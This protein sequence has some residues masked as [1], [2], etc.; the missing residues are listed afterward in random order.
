MKLFASL[1]GMSMLALAQTQDLSR[2]VSYQS[3]GATVNSIL[4]TLQKETG[5]VLTTTAETGKD[6]VFVDVKDVPLSQFLEQLSLAVG[7]EWSR[8]AGGFRLVRT[9]AL[10]QRQSAEDRAITMTRL[11]AA[12]AKAVTEG[13]INEPFDPAEMTRSAQEMR[14]QLE[15]MRQNGGR[16]EFRMP[17]VIGP[18]GRMLFKLLQLVPADVLAFTRTGERHVFATNPTAMQK[19]LASV[20][21][22]IV[23]QSL[24]EQANFLQSSQRGARNTGRDPRQNQVSPADRLRN[25]QIGKIYVI[26]T[27][28]SRL[29][30]SF[31]ARVTDVN[32]EDLMFG[33]TSLQLDQ[34]V[35]APTLQPW[36]GDGGTIDFSP[37][38]LEFSKF[39]TARR[40]L[41]QVNAGSS[42][43]MT[44]PSQELVEAVLNPLQFEPLA[45]IPGEGLASLQAVKKTNTIIML[46]DE[47]LEVLNRQALAGQVKRDAF[48][49]ALQTDVGLQFQE[50]NGW[51]TGRPQEWAMAF[52]SR[53]DR[54]QLQ[55][56]ISI[57][58]NSAPSV[59]Q[60]A[61]YAMSAPRTRDAGLDTMYA[62]LASGQAGSSAIMTAKGYNR[63][64]YVVF[65]K[66]G[67][68]QRQALLAGQPM[69]I[70]QA[71]VARDDLYSL[72]FYS[73][74]GPQR[75]Q[76]GRGNRD[77]RQAFEAQLSSRVQTIAVELYS[78]I[79][80]GGSSILNFGFAQP[81]GGIERTDYLVS[82]VPN[83]GRLTMR[84]NRIRSLRLKSSKT[85]A[86][87][88]LDINSYAV[89]R[90]TADAGRSGRGNGMQDITQYDLF[91]EVTQTMIQLTLE[92]N[93][94]SMISRSLADVQPVPNSKFGNFESLSV[95]LREQYQRNYDQAFL[96]ITRSAG[97][98][99]DNRRT[100]PP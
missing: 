13:K 61:S 85:G 72:V 68:T 54:V 25:S 23:R 4:T 86:T 39:I 24:N 44:P 66:F 12:I 38:S 36:S 91:Q 20:A 69:P 59:E 33:G 15:R 14:E 6:V 7:A 75:R 1:L 27:R 96:N 29:T 32:G 100:P 17:R 81:S 98:N 58:Q 93:P 45:T 26:V 83:D 41:N 52:D 40:S 99:N 42:A 89:M 87:M 82:G 21:P 35:A 94:P 10:V 95:D 11:K 30:Y 84:G 8:E 70:G 47:A 62:Q 22:Q 79:Q 49:A 43:G 2:T 31:Q 48:Y 60:L 53:V 37:L 9:A 18:D 57:L 73:A 3:K 97:R 50:T 74:D 55:G 5:V 88:V 56:M 64:A 34:K 63:E 28:P 65:G 92:M 16:G 80:Q 51:W 76:E 46:P 77:D 78:G 67:G 90:A 71:A 19:G